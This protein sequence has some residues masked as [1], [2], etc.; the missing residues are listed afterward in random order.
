MGFLY[1]TISW[2][3]VSGG[4]IWLWSKVFPTSDPGSVGLLIMYILGAY[5]PFSIAKK[6]DW[7]D[8]GDF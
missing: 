8:M 7:F 1:I 4:L 6:F 5:I 3:I 2:F